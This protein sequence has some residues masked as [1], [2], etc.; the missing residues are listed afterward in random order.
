MIH[1]E[2]ALQGLRAFRVAR[3]DRKGAAACPAQGLARQ[4]FTSG[5]HLADD[6][7]RQGSSSRSANLTE[8]W[9]SRFRTRSISS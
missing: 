9:R 1:L 2:N 8:V 3:I 6:A 7:G 5:R 4:V